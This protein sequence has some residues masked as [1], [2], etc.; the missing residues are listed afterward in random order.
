MT[1]LTELDIE[2]SNITVREFFH[3][4]SDSLEGT[5][6][7]PFETLKDLV[8]HGLEIREGAAGYVG[9]DLVQVSDA[10]LA[11]TYAK[12]FGKFDNPEMPLTKINGQY[13]R[14]GDLFVNRKNVRDTFLKLGDNTY[15]WPGSDNT[16]A[17]HPVTPKRNF[18]DSTWENITI[19]II[20]NDRL[21]ISDSRNSEIFHYSEM[22]LSDKRNGEPNRAWKFLLKLADL[23]T[24][25]GEFSLKSANFNQK[26]HDQKLINTAKTR[27]KEI[28]KA[29]KDATGINDDP[30]YNYRKIKSYKPKFNLRGCKVEMLR[31]LNSNIMGKRKKI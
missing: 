14:I 12:K 13:Q 4:L 5:E 16:E 8:R 17:H 15:P 30:F 19:T 10:V 2:D 3:T 18:S 25:F 21:K 29:L 31:D 23:Y 26:T 20:S 6:Q 1:Y 11:I 22:G 28:R 24:E 7:N 9:D 27:V